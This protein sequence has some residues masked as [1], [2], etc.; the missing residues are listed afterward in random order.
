VLF[1]DMPVFL[2]CPLFPGLLIVDL[3]KLD[4]LGKITPAG[5]PFGDFLP[6]D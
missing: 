2:L 5:G 6:A 3:F 4:F 1:I